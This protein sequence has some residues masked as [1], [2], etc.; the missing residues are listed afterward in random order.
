MI[1]LH[2]S[3]GSTYLTDDDDD[4]DDGIHTGRGEGGYVCGKRCLGHVSLPRQVPS[5]Q[6]ITERL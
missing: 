3:D 6:S 1:D 4:D 5:G 2:T